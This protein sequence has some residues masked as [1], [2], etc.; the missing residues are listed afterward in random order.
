MLSIGPHAIDASQPRFPARN[1]TRVANA[2]RV[3][4]QQ[5]G[6]TAVVSYAAWGADLLGLSEAGKLGLRRRVVVPFS[7]VK[8]GKPQLLIVRAIGER[9]MTRLSTKLKRD[10]T[11]LFS[12]WVRRRALLG[13]EQGNPRA[14]VCLGPRKWRAG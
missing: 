12:T 5:H 1:L 4:L 7:R 14:S 10:A 9:S 8:F 13:S 2:V 11:Y 3:L 6:I